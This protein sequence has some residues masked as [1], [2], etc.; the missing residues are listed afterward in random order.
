M[1]S[2]PLR[3]WFTSSQGVSGENM[4]RRNFTHN[5]KDPGLLFCNEKVQ[6]ILRSLTGK[7]METIFQPKKLGEPLEA[8]T[9]AFLT[10]A[11][12]EEQMAAADEK[13]DELLQMP[14]VMLERD[15]ETKCLS[16]DPEL[17]GY[18]NHKFIF[19]D[20]S[21]NVS[22]R[23]RLIIVREPDGRLQKASWE[24]RDRM[25]QIYFP[26]IIR[27]LTMPKMYSPEYLKEL[28]DREEH[29]FVLDSVCI[30]F[31]PDDPNYLRVTS[32]TYDA[33]DEARKY[34]DLL[35]TR[36]YGVMVFYLVWNKKMDNLLIDLIRNNRL[37][38]AADVIRIY[39]ILHPDCKSVSKVTEKD[40]ASSLLKVYVEEDAEKRSALELSLQTFQDE[41]MSDAVTK[42]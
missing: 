28:L 7:D 15:S 41:E 34:D 31:E 32:A 17:L 37:E 42:N 16:E 19:T 2:L 23:K 14:P 40:S 21:T 35:S 20:I 36:H 27:S 18:A 9:Y 22:D 25:N 4:L 5:V 30:Q 10:Q 24:V 13:A 11:E 38:N 29:L 39:H 33:I 3:R 8:P 12:L 1:C 26:R 6:G